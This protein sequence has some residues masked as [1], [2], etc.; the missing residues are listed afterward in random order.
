ME[1]LYD[2]IVHSVYITAN[3]FKTERMKYGFVMF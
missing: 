3:C 1:V 2:S